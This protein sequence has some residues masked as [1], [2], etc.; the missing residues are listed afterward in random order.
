MTTIREYFDTDQKALNAQREWELKGEDDSVIINIQCKL[1]Y[2]IEDKLKFFSLFFP[3]ESNLNAIKFILN[4]EEI[5]SGKIDNAEDIQEV[6]YLDC[7]ESTKLS[8]CTFVKN[9][10]IYIDKIL[11]K[12][13]KAFIERY[14]N[15]LG[16]KVTIRDEKYA[17]E[18]NT[19]STPLAFI[20]HDFKDKELLVR[21]LANEMRSLNCP[22]WYDEYT[23][24]LGDNLKEKI[25]EGINKTKYSI[26]I[27]SKNYITN[28]T[29]ANYEFNK[30]FKQ[31]NNI[32]I[33]I[34][35]D[36]EKNDVDNFATDLSLIF[37]TNT[38]NKSMKDLAKELV[39]RIKN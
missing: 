2:K 33:P 25:D 10:F 27:L 18:C 32:L 30:I 31:E 11:N 8:E 1:S 17:L 29:W 4:T 26:V 23:L 9:I 19:L 34:W 24:Q 6:R 36:V 3:R 37:G 20:S 16:F 5:S 21:E 35:H 14:S 12:D 13:E 7:P 39:S 28:T 22:V 38:V 15:H